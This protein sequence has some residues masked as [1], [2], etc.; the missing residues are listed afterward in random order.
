[1][2]LGS[3]V[4]ICNSQSNYYCISQRLVQNRV[5]QELSG[6]NIGMTSGG[7]KKNATSN[8]SNSFF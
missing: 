7:T 5:P 3:F 1:M 2:N 8:V 4:C 6:M